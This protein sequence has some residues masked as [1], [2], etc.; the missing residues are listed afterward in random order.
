MLVEGRELQGVA[1]DDPFA[2][3]AQDERAVDEGAVHL[4]EAFVQVAGLGGDVHDVLLEDQERF[5]AVDDEA[6]DP[7]LLVPDDDDLFGGVLLDDRQVEVHQVLFN[8]V[9]CGHNVLSPGLHKLAVTV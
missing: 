3:L 9:E 8:G 6:A 2:R 7:G 5:F 4:Q 1:E